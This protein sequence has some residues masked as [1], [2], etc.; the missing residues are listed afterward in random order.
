MDKVLQYILSHLSYYGI[1][2]NKDAIK[3]LLANV[4]AGNFEK[5]N[6]DK[7]TN[8][9]MSVVCEGRDRLGIGADPEAL[10]KLCQKLKEIKEKKVKLSKETLQTVEK[11]GEK[12]EKE[13]VKKESQSKETK[14]ESKPQKSTEKP[15]PEP[16]AEPQEPTKEK[17]E[18]TEQQP[19]TQQKSE[20]TKS[21]E[22]SVKDVG[23][24]GKSK[25]LIAAMTLAAMSLVIIK[26]MAGGLSLGK[27]IKAVKAGGIKTVAVGVAFV[28]LIIAAYC[29]YKLIKG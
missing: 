20:P 18:S 5:I 21:A 6:F 2:F 27:I 23:K 8:Y 19:K 7:L 9:V 26:V 10:K 3:E 25:Y 1:K 16:E 14:P 29:I 4:E 15:Q 17:P 13:V 22:K 11:L 28:M 12:V 24:S